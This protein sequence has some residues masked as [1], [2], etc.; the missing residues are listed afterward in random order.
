MATTRTLALCLALFSGAT[1]SSVSRTDR[2]DAEPAVRF[3]NV[4][5][6]AGIDFLLR[7]DAAGRKYQVE[8]MLGGVVV[9]DFDNDGWPDIYATNGAALPSL[10]KNDPRFHNRLYRNNRDG[11]FADVTQRAGVSGNGYSMGAAVGD[12]DNNGW[13]DLYV[14]GVNENLLYRNNGDGTFADI[15]RIA[16]V[17]GRDGSGRKLWSVAAAWLDYDNDGDLDLWVSNYCEWSPGSDPVCGGLARSARTYCSPDSYQ[18]QPNLLYRNEGRQTFK[19]VSVETGVGK[20]VGKGMG[21]AVS[22][23][24]NDGYPDVFVAHDN[25]RNQLFRNAAN[26]RFEEIGIPAGVAFNGDGRPISGMGADFRD[27]DGDGRPDIVMTGLRRETFELFRNLDGQ[28]FA[29]VSAESGILRLS[30]PWSGWSCAF[31]DFDNDGWRDFFVANGDL[32][33]GGPQP[34]RLFRNIGRGHFVDVS[35]GAGPDLQVARLHRGAAVADFDNDGRVDVVVSALNEP[36]VVLMNRGPRRRW[37]HLKMR[38]TRS[39]RSALGARVSCRTKTFQ[40]V[41]WVANSV[42]YASA[43]DLR[44]HFGLGADTLAT[45]IEVRWPCGKIQRFEEVAADQVLE[46]VEPTS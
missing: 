24:N 40:Q 15:T 4:A 14:V 26:G 31:A 45:E 8:T 12:F 21:V 35:L 3:E 32:D 36:L 30:Q 23:F 7:N 27:Y 42:G 11:T 20:L 41:A 13:E 6:A 18:G 22:D 28:E 17:D 43:S 34:N 39:N 44:V 29:D 25:A 10:Q 37:L 9:I 1:A 19:D 2:E 33:V 46:L 16:G 38:G 5:A